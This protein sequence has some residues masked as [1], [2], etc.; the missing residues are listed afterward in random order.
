MFDRAVAIYKCKDVELDMKNVTDET[1][2]IP[3][4]MQEGNANC[5]KVFYDLLAE[6]I[7]PPMGY[8]KEWGDLPKTKS[9][10]MQKLNFDGDFESFVCFLNS[11]YNVLVHKKFK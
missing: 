11:K 3:F 10:Q 9:G 1:C 7:K 6:M 5:A 2:F 8:L 4:D